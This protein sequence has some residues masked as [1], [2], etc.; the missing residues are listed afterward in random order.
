[1]YSLSYIYMCAMYRWCD[2]IYICLHVTGYLQY[3]AL[4]VFHR[5]DPCEA[6]YEM[7]SVFKFSD[8]L[9]ALNS[10]GY[11]SRGI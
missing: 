11:P 4:L 7:Q 8:V 9:F 3:A 5:K 6:K 10:D 2:Y 1:M